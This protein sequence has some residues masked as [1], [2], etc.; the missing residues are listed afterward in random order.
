MSTER[1]A[2]AAQERAAWARIATRVRRIT[3]TTKQALDNRLADATGGAVSGRADAFWPHRESLWLVGDELYAL[4]GA[5]RPQ[6]FDFRDAVGTPY[7]V[8]RRVAGASDEMVPALAAATAADDALRL[9]RKSDEPS[10]AKF[11]RRL[12]KAVRAVAE[13][14][15]AVVA[16]RG[17]CW[18]PEFVADLAAVGLLPGTTAVAVAESHAS[19]MRRVA[20]DRAAE[21]AAEAH[22]RELEAASAR[23]DRVARAA[24]A[25]DPPPYS[26]SPP[27]APP[28]PAPAAP[29]VAQPVAPPTA[30]PAVPKKQPMSSI[31]PAAR[32]LLPLA[33]LE[34]AAFERRGSDAPADF[35]AAV[36]SARVAAT[37]DPR[38]GALALIEV[39]CL[40]WGRTEPEPSTACLEALARVLSG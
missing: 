20:E 17:W 34:A 18:N 10:V 24:A 8:R 35:A 31:V 27:A 37:T 21:A 22:A 12:E 16:R 5:D 3:A 38:A 39:A 14:C 40:L 6:V 19:V 26:A 11:E 30:P 23:A 4:A 7:G 15:A 1:K 29:P 25:A 13:V 36:D 32:A 9:A 28:A 2:E 33:L